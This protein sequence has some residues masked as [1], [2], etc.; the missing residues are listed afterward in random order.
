MVGSL[1]GTGAPRKR[2]NRRFLALVARVSRVAVFT[3]PLGPRLGARQLGKGGEHVDHRGGVGGA[4]FQRAAFGA[5]A[6]R[7]SGGRA[8]TV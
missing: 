4:C 7:R 3:G 8:A 1:G 6:V 2:A 5:E